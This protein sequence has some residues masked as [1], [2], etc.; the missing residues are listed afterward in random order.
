MT[1]KKGPRFMT[2]AEYDRMNE[3][4]EEQ[5]TTNVDDIMPTVIQLKDFLREF[6]LDLSPRLLN[7]LVR[8]EEP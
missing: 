8:V 2:K 6:N 3:V 1:T 4:Q 7:S 5:V